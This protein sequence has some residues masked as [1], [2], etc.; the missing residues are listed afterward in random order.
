MDVPEAL[1]G[2]GATKKT[3]M[4]VAEKI[5][6]GGSF[7]PAVAVQTGIGGLPVLYFG[8]EEQRA[9]WVDGIVSGDVLTAY[10]LTEAGS[11]S[12]ALGARST[13][14]LDEERGAAG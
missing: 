3:A 8:T 6:L 13:A 9:R 5:G 10:A 12:D 14:V 7:A 4:L 1:G 11:G 2:L